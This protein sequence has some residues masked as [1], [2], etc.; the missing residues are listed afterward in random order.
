MD[1]SGVMDNNVV[2]LAFAFKNDNLVC[3][4]RTEVIGGQRLN[5]NG[6]AEAFQTTIFPECQYDKC[7]FYNSKWTNNEDRCNKAVSSSLVI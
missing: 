4:F 7:P 2:E 3:P 1:M 6:E 5:D